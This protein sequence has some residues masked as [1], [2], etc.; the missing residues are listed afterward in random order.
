MKRGKTLAVVLAGAAVALAI[1]LSAARALATPASGVSGS[2]LAQGTIDEHININP[3]RDEPSVVTVQKVTV[4]P[5]GTTGWHSH[6][7]KVLA[8]VGAGTLTLSEHDCSVREVARGQGF[9]E[10]PGHVHMASNLGEV[11]VE[12]YVTYVSRPGAQLRVDEAAPACNA[13]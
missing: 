6:D 9:V 2:V 5:G 4:Q 13:G 8:V 11:P 12:V 3:S 1:G 7:A 10:N